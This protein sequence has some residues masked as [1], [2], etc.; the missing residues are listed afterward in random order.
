MRFNTAKCSREGG[1][2]KNEDYVGYI[3]KPGINAWVVADGLGG[4]GG[5]EVASRLAV[6]TILGGFAQKPALEHDNIRNI[7]LH[8]NNTIISNQK[9]RNTMKSTVVSLFS[10]G[11][12]IMW[13]HIGDSRL[14]R[15]TNGIL[16]FQTKDHSVSQMSVLSGEITHDKIRF[17]EDRNKLLRVLGDE[18]TVKPDITIPAQPPVPGEAF[19]LCTDGFWEYVL[20]IE[21]EI[22]LAK[23][24]TPHEWVSSLVGRLSRRVDG[25]N[26]NFSCIAVFIN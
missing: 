16:T 14:Y 10:D 1:R 4:H 8:A 12:N 13:A 7:L 25:K 26:D 6:E 17:H 9:D 20:E 3:D 11:T 19:L 5:G 23:A 2:E 18:D 15:F 24:E 21:M 22:D